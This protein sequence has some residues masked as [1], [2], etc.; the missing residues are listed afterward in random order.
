MF[1]IKFLYNSFKCDGNAVCPVYLSIPPMWQYH[2]DNTPNEAVITPTLWFYH[3]CHFLKSHY[4]EYIQKHSKQVISGWCLFLTEGMIT[5]VSLKYHT[6]GTVVW[7]LV[8]SHY[9]GNGS[10]SFCVELPFICRAFDKG[11]STT[12]W[13]LWFDLAGNRTWA[14]Q[15]RRE[16]SFTRLLCWWRQHCT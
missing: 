6:A 10:T 2:Y 5:T 8:R 14:S 16:W 9:S 4:E 1:S 12:I 13:N 7:Y 11:A 15:T 3:L